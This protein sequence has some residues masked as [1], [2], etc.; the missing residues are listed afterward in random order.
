MEVYV[1]RHARV[2]TEEGICYGQSDIALRE[3][4]SSELKRIQLRVPKNFDLIISSPLQRCIQTACHFSTNFQT[5]TRLM[6]MNFGEWEMKKWENLPEKELL[7][8][9]ENY[10]NHAPPKGETLQD[11]YQRAS[12]FLDS[13]RNCGHSKVLLVTHSG[14][15]RCFWTYLLQIPL[16]HTFRIPVGYEEVFHFTLGQIPKDDFIQSK[17]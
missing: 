8:W 15:I 4:Y 5:D 9:T 13:L 1:I 2:K 11:V 14:M 10:V 17:S 7:F 3:N 12:D 16:S 6:E